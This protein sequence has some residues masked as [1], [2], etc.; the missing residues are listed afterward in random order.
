MPVV[1][2]AQPV[3]AEVEAAPVAE[4]PQEFGIFTPEEPPA[5][6]PVV[7]PVVEPVAEEPKYEELS[8]LTAQ[9][10]E[11]KGQNE[12]LRKLVTA[13]KDEAVDELGMIED[14]LGDQD[15]RSP[16]EREIQA[17]KEQ[18]AS[19]KE[20]QSK[21]IADLRQAQQ[22]SWAQNEVAKIDAETTRLS[23]EYPW[24]EVAKKVNPNF[25]DIVLQKAA[26]SHQAG[27][28]KSYDEIIKE[29]NEVIQ[30]EYMA[31]VDRLISVPNA[32]KALMEKL[33]AVAP[34]SAPPPVAPAPE[35]PTLTGGM[36]AFS[37]QS[38]TQDIDDPNDAFNA[39]VKMMEKD[40]WK[41]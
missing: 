2:E 23:T 10:L 25:S 11:L 37:E 6:A 28:P 30:S 13:E 19:F 26:E 41:Q 7:E 32:K 31:L 24:V 21:Q 18:V 1:P 12:E 3:V 15:E 35:S 33:G 16:E 9:M 39:A 27:A 40:G 34:H 36:S 17:L 29:S 38:V 22:T 20:E 4:E 5:P 8:K 14:I